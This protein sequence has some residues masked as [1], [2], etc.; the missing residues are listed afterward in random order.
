LFEADPPETLT[1]DD[2]I[3]PAEP[4]AAKFQ[5]AW[6]VDR[7]EF[8][9]I[10]WELSDEKSALWQ[11]AE[12]LQ[13][14][15]REGLRVLAI[16][17][18]TRGQGRS[19]LAITLTRM[20]AATGLNAVLL[21]GDLDLPS[22]ADKLQMEIRSGWSDALANG[23]SAEEVAV[24]S[25]EDRFTVLPLATCDQ[26]AGRRPDTAATAHM[27]DRL[28]DHFDIVLIDAANVNVIGGWI[29]G[30][31][32]T[33]QIDAALVIQDARQPDEDAMQACLRRLQKLGIENLG[34]V[35]NFT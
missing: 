3:T 2:V 23:L 15:C 25:V 18:P 31:D 11:A 32:G 34:L 24:H 9:P 5:A 33:C 27:I 26:A 20:L 10:V 12:Q 29:P 17:S 1:I 4:P 21:E 30:T 13:L 7:F 28:R 35:E 6:E 16:S 8:E 22:L 14:A 19:T